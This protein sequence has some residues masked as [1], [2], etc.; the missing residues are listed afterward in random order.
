MR[1]LRNPQAGTWLGSSTA[2]L[3]AALFALFSTNT[4]QLSVGSTVGI[5]AIAA[6]GLTVVIGRAGQL[7]LGQAGFMAIGAYA[8]A[9]GTTKMGLSFIVAV[10]MGVAVAGALGVIVGYAALR[11]RG[12]YLAMATLALGGI[13]DG[14]LTA[15]GRLG[16]E[17][18]L[19][20]I[21]PLRLGTTF[22]SPLASYTF[23]WIV[24]GIVLVACGLYLRGRAGQELG[25]LRDDELAAASVGVNNRFRKVQAFVLSAVVGAIAG[26]ILAANS[27]VI[28]PTLFTPLIS[29]QIFLM[30]VIGGLGSLGGAVAGAAIVVWLVQLTPGTG[31]AAYVVLGVVVVALMAFFPRG[32]GG[33]LTDLARRWGPSAPTPGS[34]Q[35]TGDARESLPAPPASSEAKLH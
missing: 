23:I 22:S 19:Y 21:P 24:V 34:G 26:G 28:D 17:G 7:A 25:A 9:Y 3:G 32:L 15:K 12:N 30:V 13:I 10:L 1:R 18:G 20:G 29:F 2:L 6:I 11:L 27:S 8:V 4:Y 16:G 35:P 5:D 31:D 14:L 33:M